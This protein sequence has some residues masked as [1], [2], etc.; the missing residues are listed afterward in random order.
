MIGMGILM[1]RGEVG[2]LVWGVLER[3]IGSMDK[4][5]S[6]EYVCEEMVLSRGKCCN[7]RKT[8]GRGI[9]GD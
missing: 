7:Y 1:L 3:G 8:I 2:M 6:M 5:E 9:I 4:L